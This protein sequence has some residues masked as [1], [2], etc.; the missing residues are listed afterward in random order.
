MVGVMAAQQQQRQQLVG[1][2][3]EHGRR[4]QLRLDNPGTTEQCDS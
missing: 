3:T 4:P 1:F 2:L